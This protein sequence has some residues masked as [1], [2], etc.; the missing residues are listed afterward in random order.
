[1][2][3]WVKCEKCGKSFGKTDI[4]NGI[5]VICSDGD[6]S[7]DESAQAA[8][9][10]AKRQESSSDEYRSR[11]PSEGRPQ[12]Q[13]DSSVLE[14][15]IDPPEKPRPKLTGEEASNSNFKPDSP[16]PPNILKSLNNPKYFASNAQAIEFL[17][18]INFL[19]LLFGL[20][21]GFLVF[22]VGVIVNDSLGFYGFLLGLAIAFAA[23]VGW[24]ITRVFIGIAQDVRVSR[25]NSE[26][27]VELAKA[28]MNDNREI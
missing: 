21:I 25:D 1:M 3:K 20:A 14:S 9:T 15:S 10:D 4:R 8:A 17:E 23:A 7:R 19:I 2:A 18:V 28:A 11:E 6:A 24:S 13:P 22:L 26:A 27:L 16:Q 5:C 12:N